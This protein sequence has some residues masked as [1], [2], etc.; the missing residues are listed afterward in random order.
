MI[1]FICGHVRGQDATEDRLSDVLWSSDELTAH[2][3]VQAGSA[4][5]LGP[6]PTGGS[7]RNTFTAHT[8][9]LQMLGALDGRFDYYIQWEFTKSPGLLDTR[10]G[11]RINR[12]LAFDIGMFKTPVGQEFLTSTENTDL[13][14]GAS[15]LGLGP[16]RDAGFQARVDIT[17]ELRFQAGVFNGTGPLF[18]S[19]NTDFLSMGR[20]AYTGRTSNDGGVI[21]AGISGGTD[22]STPLGGSYSLVAVDVRVASSSSFGSAEVL[23]VERKST[24]LSAQTRAYGLHMTGGTLVMQDTWIKARYQRLFAHGA[25]GPEDDLILN[26]SY[27]ASRRFGLSIEG[28]LPLRELYTY[29]VPARILTQVQMYL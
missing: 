28:V 14:S 11:Y 16:Q 1:L 26:L 8:S 23:V 9:R 12:F 21:I 24:S 10:I 7:Y 20:L 13:I 29:T 22:P 19:D 2:I 3:L 18:V 4:V 5:R 17:D 15:F 25:S 6:D 27:T